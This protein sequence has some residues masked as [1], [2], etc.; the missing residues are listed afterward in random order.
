MTGPSEE[1]TVRMAAAEQALVRLMA[2][3]LPRDTLADVRCLVRRARQFV[4]LRDAA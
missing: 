1:A 3:E 2:G 4:E